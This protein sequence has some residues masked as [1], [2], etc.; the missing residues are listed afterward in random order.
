M[1]DK[2]RN[3]LAGRAS[4]GR[5]VTRSKAA[6]RLPGTQGGF[7]LIAALFLLVVVASLGGY[8]VR[9]ATVQHS[10]S[11]LSAQ[12]VRALYA[13]V[14]G[15]EWVAYELRSSPGGCPSVP[16]TFNVEGFTV[17]LAACSQT[18]VSEAGG[19]YNLYDVTVDASRGVFGDQDFVSRS[20]RATVGE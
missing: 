5:R 8:M 20:L 1:S 10:S 3:R 4:T 17:S 11:S 14:S 7:T 18:T 16:T 6:G 9:L 15:L 12:H 13:A 2:H 19:S